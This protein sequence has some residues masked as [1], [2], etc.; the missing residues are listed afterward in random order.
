MPNI[1][2]WS[3]PGKVSASNISIQLRGNL[4]EAR[5]CYYSRQR[6]NGESV[7]VLKYILH[8]LK[9]NLGLGKQHKLA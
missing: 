2:N 1:V 7:N 3:R 5:I 4:Q 6:L 9:I 8:Q